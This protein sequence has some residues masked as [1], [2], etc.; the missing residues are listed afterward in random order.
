[1]GV[2]P[3]VLPPYI[4]TTEEMRQ[5]E[6]RVFQAGLAIAAL[7]EKVGQSLSQRIQDLWPQARYPQLGV[8]VGPGHNGG[9]ALVVARELVLA[10]YGV[11][12]W[13]PFSRAKSLTADHLHYAQFLGIPVT[14]NIAD[15]RH[16]HGII[17][18]L[19]GFGLERPLTGALLESV[20]QL[21]SWQ[22]AVISIDIPS[23]LDSD[24]GTVLGGVIK[25]DHTLCL[26]LWKLGLMQDQAL[27]VI[28]TSELIDIGL[29]LKAITAVL[30]DRPP[31]Q[32]LTSELWQSLPLR[33][34]PATYKYRQGHS[35]LVGGS[36][37]YGGSIVL[38]ALAARETGVGMLSVAVPYHL[39]PLILS[40]VPDALV[41]G[42]PE[43]K[44]GA[45]AQLPADLVLRRFQG[46]ACGPG[47]TTETP[48]VV[49][50]LLGSPCP[51]ILDADALNLLAQG[52]RHQQLATRAAPTL[53]TPHWGE[54]DRLF[55]YLTQEVNRALA[56]RQG[57]QNTGAMILLKG[58]RT[59]I[60]TPT[61]QLW[62]NPESTPAL[63]RGGSGDV[64]TGLLAGLWSQMDPLSATLAGTWWHAQAGC[65]AAQDT[66]AM[67]VNAER[68]THYLNPALRSRPM[69]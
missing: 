60:A 5:I 18:G 41:I 20:H 24:C 8:L 23:G 17:D 61:G 28:G 56:A 7:M 26:G 31:V 47:L 58:A 12:L 25:A 3:S 27:D 14:E 2:H 67:G 21:N 30:G 55:P 59:A 49:D 6:G 45:I 66:T 34:S 46:I 29:P 50:H 9:D 48:V 63:A 69:S 19:F 42:C 40:Q 53:L 22:K 1:M 57:A 62:I 43:T 44:N 33:R 38:A 54:F 4:V 52:D 37:T 68:L 32:C 15:L 65:L 36:A 11:I 16:C 10:G 64:L 51:L 39:K 35:L 13:H